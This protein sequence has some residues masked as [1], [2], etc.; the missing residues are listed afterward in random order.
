V[1]VD[2]DGTNDYLIQV[3][4]DPESGRRALLA[5]RWGDRADAFG[6]T[7]F[8]IIIEES[9]EVVEWAGVPRLDPPTRPAP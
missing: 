3:L 8:Y 1:D 6:P 4:I 7:V 2:R 9:D 5:R